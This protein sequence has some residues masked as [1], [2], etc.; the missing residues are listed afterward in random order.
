MKHEI[1]GVKLTTEIDIVEFLS[2]L[3]I[4]SKKILIEAL[5][6]QEDVIRHVTD[7]ILDGRAENG[8]CSAF[9]TTCNHI[10]F[11]PELQKSRIRIS[12]SLS[13][14][15]Y[16]QIRMLKIK[17]QNLAQELENARQIQWNLGGNH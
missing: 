5:S 16:E 10:E 15:A 9:A 12:E 3:D 6:C 7:Q 4:E 13:E 14:L 1:K 2:E 17:N 8:W 11:L